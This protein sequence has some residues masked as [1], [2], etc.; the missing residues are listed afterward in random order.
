MLKFFLRSLTVRKNFLTQKREKKRT[1][2]YFRLQLN[3]FCHYNI[4]FFNLGTSLQT[5]KHYVQLLA[6]GKF[7]KYSYDSKTNLKLYGSETAPS[8]NLKNVVASTKIF[9][10][11]GDHFT[12]LESIQKLSGE[13]STT[14]SIHIV[15]KP[16][17]THTDFGFSQHAKRL[18]YDYLISDMNAIRDFESNSID[19]FLQCNMTTKDTYSWI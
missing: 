12:P 13:L 4:F 9:A 1:K 18:V 16:E 10:G 15:D 7:S 11:M 2:Y 17:W 8:Y 5:H 6:D 14:A 3:I 19:P